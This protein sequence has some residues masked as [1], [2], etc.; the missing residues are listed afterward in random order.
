[1]WIDI[2]HYLDFIL[3]I[4]TFA[5]ILI[6]YD[7]FDGNMI[8]RLG[9]VDIF[10]GALVNCAKVSTPQLLT[11]VNFPLLDGPGVPVIQESHGCS[12]VLVRSGVWH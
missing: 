7:C 4:L 5:A 10:Y 8:F 12:K 9:K 2:T 11:H 1:M 3:K 6:G